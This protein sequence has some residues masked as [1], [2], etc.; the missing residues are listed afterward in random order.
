LAKYSAFGTQLKM[1]NGTFQVETA[2]VVG[3]ITGNGNA[4]F[5]IT[6]T[7]MAGT[8]LA[9]SVAVLEN[10]TASMVAAK[11]RATIGATAAVTAMYHV[12]G[13]GAEV[14]LT[15]KIATANVADLNIAYTNDTCSGL[16]PDATSDNTVVGGQ[17]EVFTTIAQV[18]NISGP[19]LSLDF[20]DVTTHDS[21]EA[22][23]EVVATVLRSGEV[24][25]DLV[26][27]PTT[28]THSNGVGLLAVMPRRATRNFQVIFPD[29]GPTTWAF[30]AEVTGFE[31]DAPHDG[32]L[33]ASVT[34][35]L[36]GQVTLA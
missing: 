30:A 3:T 22:W 17:A 29:T 18:R 6:S 16:T 25:L 10:D 28:P 14:V 19:G 26:W 4:T 12:G 21:T 5:T 13:S 24:T 23:E 2:T 8:P 34:L 27:D 31:P 1:G 20:E 36:T 15:R 7:G 35:K 32:A 33:T 9:I 11:A